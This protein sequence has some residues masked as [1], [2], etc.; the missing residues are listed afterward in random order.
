MNHFLVERIWAKMFM[1][2]IGANGK[3]LDCRPPKALS[4]ICSIS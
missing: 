3:G 4:R 2:E 1:H